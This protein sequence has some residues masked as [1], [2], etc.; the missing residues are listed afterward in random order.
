MTHK[1]F[2]GLI[3]L[4]AIG[5]GCV[6]ETQSNKMSASIYDSTTSIERTDT[7]TFATGCFWCTEAVFEQLKGVLK[8]TSGYS[9]GKKPNPSYE[10]VSTGNSGYAEC[11]QV[12]YEPDKIS[13][14]E[15]LEVFFEVHDPTSLNKQGA[16]EGPQYRSAIF[17]HDAAQKDKAEYYVREL[18][19]SGAYDKPIVTEV[20]PFGHFYSAEDYHQDYYQTNKYSNPYCAVVIRPKLEK[21]QKV[22]A[23]KLKN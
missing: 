19:K 5:V 23:K 21:F 16:D 8:V 6:A 18:G 14:D 1:I 20:S 10:E 12:V 11:V 15:L 7:A 13:Y 22:F 9:G 2:A 4:I 3:A 17:Y